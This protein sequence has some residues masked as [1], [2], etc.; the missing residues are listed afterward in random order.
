MLNL[1]DCRCPTGLVRWAAWL[2]YPTLCLLVIPGVPVYLL[3][4]MEKNSFIRIT[5]LCVFIPGC[6]LSLLDLRFTSSSLAVMVF[7][8]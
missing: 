2:K 7:S 1:K 8:S 4:V 3:R 5:I 6:H